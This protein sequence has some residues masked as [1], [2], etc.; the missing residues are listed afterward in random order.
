MSCGCA[1]NANGGV[2]DN[3]AG[4][5]APAF[6]P[7]SGTEGVCVHATDYSSMRITRG[8]EPNDLSEPLAEFGGDSKAPK[9]SKR[10]IGNAWR[11][12]RQKINGADSTSTVESAPSPSETTRYQDQSESRSTTEV[13]V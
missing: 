2:S 13:S 12:M 8:F 7:Y 9:K 5:G 4:I 3:I 1:N 11:W 6:L 10:W